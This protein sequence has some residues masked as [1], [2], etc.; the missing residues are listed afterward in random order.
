MEW[1]EFANFGLR[2]Q[3]TNRP[4]QGAYKVAR[5]DLSL[6]QHEPELQTQA[7]KSSFEQINGLPPPALSSSVPESHF[8]SRSY[9]EPSF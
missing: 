9:D 7:D 3:E 5:E 6:H 2:K 1:L 8:K 4:I